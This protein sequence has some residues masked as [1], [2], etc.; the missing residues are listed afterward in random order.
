ML[1]PTIDSKQALIEHINR[2]KNEFMLD[3]TS[4]ENKTVDTY[5]SAL[6]DYLEDINGYYLHVGLPVDTKKPSWQL[7]ADALSG[8]A[9]YE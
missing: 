2:L 3:P 6:A 5:L 8:A 1:E 9:I 7:F 4:W